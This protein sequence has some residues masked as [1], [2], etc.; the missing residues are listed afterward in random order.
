MS[1]NYLTDG[2][3]PQ[4]WFFTR[5]HKRIALL[6]LVSVSFFFLFGGLAALAMRVALLSPHSSWLQPENYNKMFTLHGAAG[7]R[8]LLFA[9]SG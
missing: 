3:T 8:A 1:K 2:W 6:Y 9:G 5:D 4:S 7:H